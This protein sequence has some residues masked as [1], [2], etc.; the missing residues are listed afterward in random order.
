MLAGVRIDDERTDPAR[1]IASV[2][3]V[4]PRSLR[5]PIKQSEYRY[6]MA[7]IEHAREHRPYDSFADA[8]GRINELNF[9]LP[10]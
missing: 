4:W 7:R 8:R 2:A 10:W 3:D 6:L 1:I 9:Q 5:A